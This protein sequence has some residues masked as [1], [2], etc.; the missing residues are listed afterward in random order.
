MKQ[1]KVNET[2]AAEERA[3]IRINRV[4]RE[5]AGRTWVRGTVMQFTFHAL[6]FAEHA[7]YSDYEIERSR[8]SKLCITRT[9]DGT[10]CY[11][12]DRGLDRPPANRHA[13]RALKLITRHLAAMIFGEMPEST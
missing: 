1:L 5:Y 3:L 6:V 10:I 2:C 9:R 4:T 7:W 12:W 8:I 13:A 11:A